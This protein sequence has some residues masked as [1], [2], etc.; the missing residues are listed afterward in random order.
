MA[1]LADDEAAAKNLYRTDPAS[2]SRMLFRSSDPYTPALEGY[3]PG[4]TPH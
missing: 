2:D 3:P 4:G 1:H